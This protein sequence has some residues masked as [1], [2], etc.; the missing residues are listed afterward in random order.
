MCQL[1]YSQPQR[2]RDDAPRAI[3]ALYRPFRTTSLNQQTQHFPPPGDDRPH[4]TYFQDETTDSTLKS[5]TPSRPEVPITFPPA[6]NKA[7]WWKMAL[8]RR[9]IHQRGRNGIYFF[10][11]FFGVSS[12]LT[13]YVGN[14]PFIY[15]ETDSERDKTLLQV[16]TYTAEEK[17][18]KF[19]DDLKADV[20]PG[21]RSSKW[22][23]IGPGHENREDQTESMKTA[24]RTYPEPRRGLLGNTIR[25][26][27]RVMMNRT[28]YN[29][30]DRSSATILN[31][32]WALCGWPWV[33][34]GGVIATILDESMGRCA[35]MS[36]PAKTGVTA[37]LKLDY[38]KIWRAE[39]TAVVY[40]KVTEVS[41]R[42]ALVTAKLVT[43]DDGV[44]LCEASA[45]FVVPKKYNLAAIV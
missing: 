1:I 16:M 2:L 36:F 26:T 30:L 42:K 11:F 14:N 29:S 37:N 27:H 10:I 28:Y 39:Q 3:W 18:K 12:F 15:P 35:I 34:H 32:G 44:V 41:E 21:T 9:F 31:V 45:I 33:V 43:L 13:F 8:W 19:R 23:A 4:K 22:I 6:R 5:R 24:G 40:T 17:A 25:G 20:S 7:P 38:R